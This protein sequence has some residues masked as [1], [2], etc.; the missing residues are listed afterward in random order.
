MEALKVNQF[1]T[2]LKMNNNF[3]SLDNIENL[4]ENK[5]TPLTVNASMSS[6]IDI[7]K[8]EYKLESRWNKNNNENYILNLKEEANHS[9][10]RFTIWNAIIEHRK[11]KIY[12]KTKT[13]LLPKDQR[14]DEY[15]VPVVFYEYDG[16]V[17]VCIVTRQDN[18]LKKVQELINFKNIDVAVNPLS[19][20][21]NIIEWL[22]WRYMSKKSTLVN[23]DTTLLNLLS[24][25]GTIL[26]GDTSDLLKGRS[27]QISNL[28]VTKAVL[29]LGDPLN[30]AMI[31]LNWKKSE[32]QFTYT[33]NGSV[34]VDSNN[35]DLSDEITKDVPSEEMKSYTALVY[36]AS[37]V[38]PRLIAL[39]NEEAQEFS[40]GFETFKQKLATEVIEK[41]IKKNNL[42]EV[43]L[44]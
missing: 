9:L 27:P 4:Q 28:D 32:L 39:S 37:T 3:T 24:F 35:L 18:Q 7:N 12:N 22:F 44:S 6:K 2:V 10:I 40:E 43:Y 1:V 38:L 33:T 21:G 34:S 29:A 30:S 31:R 20:T 36:I 11:R 26:D 16:S 41:L 15:N 25:E 8:D 14:T 23:E 13:D 19:T 42:E 5:K 17:Y